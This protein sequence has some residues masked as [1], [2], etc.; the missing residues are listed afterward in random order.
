[1]TDCAAYESSSSGG[2]KYIYD[3]DTRSPKTSTVDQSTASWSNI[4]WL[5]VP[6]FVYFRNTQASSTIGQS[7]QASPTIGQRTQASPC[8][9]A[10]GTFS[11][12]TMGSN[13]VC[14][15]RRENNGE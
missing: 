8:Y 3:I 2:K 12:D 5:Q 6:L 1:V 11:A 7:N 15:T 9:L 4:Q 14:G 13:P 10:S